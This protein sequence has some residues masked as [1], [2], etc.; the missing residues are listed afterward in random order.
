MSRVTKAALYLAALCWPLAAE[1]NRVVILKIDGLPPRALEQNHLP[2][3]EKIFKQNGTTLDNFYVRGLSLSAPSWSLL[4]T[5]RH[6]EI[7]GNVE[8]DRYTLRPYDYLNFVPFYFSAAT[9]GRVDMRGV[10]LLDD[11]GVPLLLDRFPL[12]QRHQSFQLLQRGVRWESLK[13]AL[14]RLV[15]KAP[16]DLLDE[17][18]VG[19][20]I[21]NSLNRQFEQ[22]LLVALRN[23]N[24][25]YLDLFTGEYDHVSHLTNDPV[26]QRHEL[27]AFDAFVGKVWNTIQQTPLASTTTLILVSDHGMNSAPDVFSQGYNLVD[28]F[29][30]K[31]GGAHHVLTNRHPLSEFKVRGLDPFV[32]MVITPTSQSDYLNG[33]GNQYPT[34]MLDLDGN[35]RASIGLRNNSFNT[36]QVFLDQLTRK[37]LP[38]PTRAVAID[39][40]M[41]EL[42]RVRDPWSSDIADLTREMANLDPDIVELRKIVAAQP[43]KWTK[44]Q[45][46]QELHRAATR[47]SRK[48]AVME[49]DRRNYLAYAATIARLLKLTPADFDPGKF[50]LTDVIPA[51]SLGPSN[52]LWDLQNYVTGP[53]PEGF[54]LTPEGK[55]DWERSF[56]RTN[57]FH[58]LQEIA[59]RNNVQADVS[60]RPVDFIAVDTSQGTWL[61][62]DE[63]H[64][65]LIYQ[66]RYQ[67]VAHLKAARDGSISYEPRP[68]GPG[69]P[70]SYF[71]DPNLAVPQAWL[72]QP[73]TDAEWLA[74]THRTRYSNAIVSLKEQL[75]GKTTMLDG[76]PL[77]HYNLRKRTLRQ[78]DLLVI[79]HDHWNFNVRGFNPGGNHGSFLRDSTH[80]VLMF[81]GGKETGIP[82]GAHI[83]E[84]YDSLSFVPTVL[85]LMGRPE[86]DLPGPII[87]GLSSNR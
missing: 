72:N 43:K 84:P 57:Y 28:W 64:Q 7:R 85:N 6:L 29:N 3:I 5:G 35:E 4:D 54:V 34:V 42:E 77:D 69:Y 58:A 79:A 26:S 48:L 82:S 49:D 11:L 27:E 46:A 83:A 36:L 21:G 2:N 68:L 12:N 67:P 33:Q 25:R 51:R 60:A 32:S 78:T 87:K 30:S 44:E 41:E 24:L 52:S 76:T 73:H 71:E 17:W 13:S 50:K 37:T 20:S 74:A 62:K 75:P 31:A 53:G 47:Q 14:K 86:P 1:T 16:G 38:P 65:A 8:Y 45:I 55:F 23:P 10:E 40:F 15:A 66:G 81:S 61:Y 59:V 9:A 18:I 39:A 63:E 70:L 56:S 22:D 80:S 19:L